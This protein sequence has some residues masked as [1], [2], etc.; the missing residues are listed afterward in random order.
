MRRRVVRLLHGRVVADILY[1]IDAP[2]S[3]KRLIL[4]TPVESRSLFTFISTLFE[5]STLSVPE[6]PFDTVP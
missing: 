4:R 1:D 6:R 3:S 2:S 5:T